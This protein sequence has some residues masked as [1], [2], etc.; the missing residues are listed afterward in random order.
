MNQQN[1]I[2]G[3]IAAAIGAYFFLRPREIETGPP[4]FLE[5]PTM[6]RG[7]RNHN[8]MNLRYYESIQWDGQIGQDASGYARFETVEMG[9]R[10]GVK[11]LVNG[12]FGRGLNTP[13]EIIT[14]YAPSHENPTDS[15]ITFIANE[16]GIQPDDQIQLTRN[17]MMRLTA[18]IIR[19]ENGVQ[20]YEMST[21]ER[22]VTLG[23]S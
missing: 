21:I 13:R 4:T 23:M 3:L 22:G 10:A 2:I 17:S 11:N 14:R 18:A 12:Y 7:I 5:A 19:F 8:P 20:P 6:P 15:Y 9:I 16:M 1:V